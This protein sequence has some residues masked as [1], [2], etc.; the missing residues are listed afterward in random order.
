MFN[1]SPP[2]STPEER[3][4][5][6]VQGMIAEYERA[7]IVERTRRGKR[8]RARQGSV[9][10]LSGAPY[11]YRYMKKTDSS[12]AYY[13]VVEAEAVV[14]RSVFDLFTMKQ[15][16]IGAITRTLNEQGIIDTHRRLPLGAQ[17]GVGDASKPSLCGQ[18]LLRQNGA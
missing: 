12:S 8:H 11:G 1:K 4:L 17:H 3:L 18:G 15:F 9:N 13:E 14:V 10:V 6:Q 2:A 7:Q 5:T 16:S